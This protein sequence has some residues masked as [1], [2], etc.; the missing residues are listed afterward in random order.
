MANYA[1]CQFSPT[2]ERLLSTLVHEAFNKRLLQKMRATA[3]RDE[4]VLL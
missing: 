3:P 1:L 4:D 2:K